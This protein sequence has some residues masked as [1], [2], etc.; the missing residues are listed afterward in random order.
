MRCDDNNADMFDSLMF[1]LERSLKK[2]NNFVSKIIMDKNKNLVL[3]IVKKE[4]KKFQI[5]IH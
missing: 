3:D 4:D 1:H 2:N 5:I